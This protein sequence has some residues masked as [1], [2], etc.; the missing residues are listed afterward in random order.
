MKTLEQISEAINDLVIRK[1]RVYEDPAIKLRKDADAKYIGAKYKV[2]S[3]KKQSKY[4]PPETCGREGCFCEGDYT[5]TFWTYKI[6]NEKG[7]IYERDIY[8]DFSLKK[9]T[10]EIIFMVLYEHKI[11]KIELRKLHYPP[12]IYKFLMKVKLI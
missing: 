10:L 8:F 7:K 12:E 5:D 9:D 1:V 6:K 4:V 11:D 3:K 2:I